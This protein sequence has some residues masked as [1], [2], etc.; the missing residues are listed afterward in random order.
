MSRPSGAVVAV[1]E[2]IRRE[3]I[4]KV[5]FT[6]DDIYAHHHDVEDLDMYMA[7]SIL[8]KKG[9]ILDINNVHDDA[10]EVLG[11]H[12]DMVYCIPGEAGNRPCFCRDCMEIAIGPPGELCWECRE[13]DCEPNK[14][15]QAPGAYGG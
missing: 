12:T 3:F 2:L 13:A 8:V 6:A 14:E 11:S 7:L 15:C 5:R 4:P 10:P 9:E 1:V